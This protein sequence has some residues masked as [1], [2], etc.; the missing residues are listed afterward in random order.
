M[1]ETSIDFYEQNDGELSETPSI[2]ISIL[3]FQTRYLQIFS[4]TTRRGTIYV[5][6]KYVSDKFPWKSLQL[7][8]S[9]IA[10]N[11]R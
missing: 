6:R 10:E 8:K 1:Y 5:N 2:E 4:S 9:A 7:C 3:T 11:K